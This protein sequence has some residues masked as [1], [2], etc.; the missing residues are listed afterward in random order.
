MP[1]ILPVI[2][3]GYPVGTKFRDKLELP[4]LSR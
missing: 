2:S 3:G 1:L 4:G